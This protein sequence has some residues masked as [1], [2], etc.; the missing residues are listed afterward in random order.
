MAEE[1]ITLIIENCSVDRAKQI[2]SIAS[3]K[4]SKAGMKIVPW[5]REEIAAIIPA[6]DSNAAEVLYFAAFPESK[7]IGKNV[8]RRWE[9][10]RDDGKLV[11][12][13]PAPV[14][15]K[16]RSNKYGIPPGLSSK[17]PKRYS[18]IV[19]LMNTKGLTYAQ[20]VE[21]IDGKND[22]PAFSIK[23]ADSLDDVTGP[24]KEAGPSAKEVIKNSANRPHTEIKASSPASSV[25]AQPIPFKV[26]DQVRQIAGRIRFSGVAK[27][28]GVNQEGG[29]V[30]VE[31]GDGPVGVPAKCVCAAGKGEGK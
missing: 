6:K 27:V 12:E 28:V 22:P 18:R 30:L 2:L 24:K 10:L 13:T 11:E 17:E 7:R 26:G 8:R 4:K 29:L 19:Y 9:M 21:R 20:A 15:H 1:K 5:A 3:V 31:Y 25:V 16:G 23:G 14:E